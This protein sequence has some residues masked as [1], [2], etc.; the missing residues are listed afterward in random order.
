ML[1]TIY[2]ITNKING[3]VYIGKTS[4]T[5]EKR[6]KEHINDSKRFR[7]EKRPLYDAM[8]KYGVENFIIEEV[9]T[10]ITDE[11]INDKEQYYIKIY[12]SY[13][14]FDNSNGYN[15]TLGG[16]SKKYK[17]WNVGEIV[18]LYINQ[19]KNCREIADIVGLDKSYIP[20]ILVSNGITIR[21]SADVIREKQGKTV[22]QLNKDT[23]EI[24]NIYPSA[25]QANLSLGK[26]RGNGT[27]R[28][29]LAARRGH[30]CAYGYLWLY[31][32]DYQE[33]KKLRLENVTLKE[34][35]QNGSS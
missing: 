29:A 33:L 13:I 30:H 8:N 7:C 31:E 35:V 34:C 11:D 32:E 20:R 27:I 25:G 14:G 23:K 16:D 6:F 5:I 26:K 3:K 1:N 4:L 21:P 10:N 2:K 18:D 17:E 9:E 22:Y 19:N 12:N 28:D 24:I 15:A